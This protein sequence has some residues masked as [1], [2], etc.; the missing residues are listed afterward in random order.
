MSGG[1]TAKAGNFVA[2]VF[3]VSLRFVK[4]DSVFVRGFLSLGM[5]GQHL[6]RSKNGTGHTPVVSSVLLVLRPFGR[7]E[8]V[9]VAAGTVHPHLVALV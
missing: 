4:L 3:G 7:Y 8:H 6:L 1:R 2:T 5:Q 9:A